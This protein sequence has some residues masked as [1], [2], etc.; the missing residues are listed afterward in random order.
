MSNPAPSPLEALSALT[1]KLALELVFAAPGKDDGLLPSNSL[2]SDMQDLVSAPGGGVPT[3]L[4]DAVAAL[5]SSVDRVFDA[6]GAFPAEELT[7]LRDWI[8]WL[9]SAMGPAMRGTPLPAF[10]PS[11]ISSVNS[12]TMPKPRPA[13]TR[14]SKMPRSTT[15]SPR[16]RTS[17]CS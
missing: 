12:R 2:V 9:Q 7:R 4:V 13:P 5:R 10:T 1:E 15:S 14:N 3:P 17:G 16:K 8:S 11:A 6:G